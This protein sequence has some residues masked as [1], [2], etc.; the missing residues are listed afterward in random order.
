MAYEDVPNRG[1]QLIAVY[2]GMVVPATI[3]TTIRLV[4]R[5]YNPPGLGLDDLC[6]AIALVSDVDPLRL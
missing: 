6:I 3:V 2:V 1:P 5:H 4:W